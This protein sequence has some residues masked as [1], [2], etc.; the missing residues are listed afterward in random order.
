MQ[1][2][3]QTRATIV[4]IGVTANRGDFIRRGAQWFQH[5]FTG[6]FRF[7]IQRLNDVLGMLG[8]L[9]QGFRA[10]QMLAANDLPEGTETLAAPRR[11]LVPGG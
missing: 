7:R 9:T 6:Q 2:H 3:H 1:P 11:L 5:Q 8:D 10:I 4:I